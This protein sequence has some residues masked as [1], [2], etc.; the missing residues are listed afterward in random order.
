MKSEPIEVEDEE[1]LPERYAVLD[2]LMA[3]LQ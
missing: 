3:W 2:D 1:L